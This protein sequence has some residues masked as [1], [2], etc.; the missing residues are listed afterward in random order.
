M[1]IAYEHLLNFL[2]DNPSL[3]DVS[4]KLFQLGHEHE[5]EDSIFDIEFTPNRGDCLSLLGL[6]RDLS[7]FY[8]TNLELS[9]YEP[10][11]PKLDLNF[12]NNELERCPSI[13]FLNI[14][15]ENEVN[16]YKDYLEDYFL[17]LKLNK[18]NFFTDI[19]NFVAYEMGQP[20]HCYDLNSI[21]ADITL[22]RNI[23]EDGFK[24][25][26][27]NEIN[28]DE[29]DMVF[30]SNNKVINLAGIVGSMH[31]SCS[32][33]SKNVLIECAYFAPESIMGKSVKHNLQSD[34]SHKFERGVDPQSQEKVLRRFIHIVNDHA[35]IK[36]LSILRKVYGESREQKLDIDIDEINKI[37]G[38]DESLENFKESLTKLDFKF[39]DKILIP[40][41]RSD[42]V[43]QNDLAEEFARV[44]GYDNIT[45]KNINITLKPKIISTSEHNVKMFLVDNGFSEVINYPF[46]DI[47]KKNSIKVDNPLDSNRRY[48]R[49]NIMDSL[50]S[51]VIYNEKRQ[52]DS[53]KLF[54]ISDVYTTD[55]K[56][57]N[58]K[59]SIIVS[60]RKGHNFRE[61]N[62]LLDKNYLKD[63]FG[64]LGIDIEKD[65]VQISRDNIDSKI[66]TKIFSLEVILGDISDAFKDYKTASKPGEGY[67]QYQPISE[68]PSSTRDLSFSIK[69]Y[70]KIDEVIKKLEH[71]NVI[72]LKESYM[73]DFYENT[74][75]NIT[76]IGYRF[77][78]QSHERTLT[79]E[80][81]DSQIK[82]IIN[83][84]LLIDSV[85]LPGM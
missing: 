11:I 33:N 19:S 9:T 42:I 1:K 46:S 69:N 54:E 44:I 45:K 53:I 60:G 52:K 57:I 40:S 64:A 65:I 14:E 80:E 61:F 36:K 39:D 75:T 10:K 15:I 38:I 25:L 24:T 29:S 72:N 59:L 73:F 16:D 26:L 20:T 74:K 18:N 47:L 63:L 84:I 7:V 37:L 35:K 51:N 34:A 68:Y 21:D 27:G 67:V 2:V 8:K 22:T 48:L 23:K 56:N 13:S 82:A 66:K 55:M 70:S 12:I 77:V 41:F 6:A 43:H 83:S 78:F 17:D 62:K 58:K 32:E 85:S 76:K 4:K 81:I 3:E 49:T 31:T 30:L 71:V 79:D 5:V 50:L 28:I